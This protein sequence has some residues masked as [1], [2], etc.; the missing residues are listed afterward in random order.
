MKIKREKRAIW[1]ICV[2]VALLLTVIPFSISAVLYET[3]FH[4]RLLILQS[5]YPWD[6]CS[7]ESMI[8]LR[9]SIWMSLLQM[10]LQIY[11]RVLNLH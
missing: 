2:V 4:R 8:L 7:K 3:T 10:N 1:V 5:M 6:H 11:R 9:R